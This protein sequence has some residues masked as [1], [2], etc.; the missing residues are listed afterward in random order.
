MHC[1]AWIP[2][3][4][5]A[6]LA[7]GCSREGAQGSQQ[8]PPPVVEFTHPVM[9]EV[10]DYEY[11]PGR[12]EAVNTVDVRA[13]VTGYLDRIDKAFKEGYEVAEKEP[14]CEIDSRLYNADLQK[15]QANLVQA[16]AHLK[17]LETEY[18]RARTLLAQR[19]TS[20]E[21]YDKAAG[22][23]DEAVAAVGVARAARDYSQLNVGFCTVNAPISGRV[24]RRMVD[25]GNLIKADDTIITTIVSLDPM[26]ASFDVDERTV[27]RIRRLIR[28]GKVKSARE[29]D[30]PVEMALADDL[31]G[32][33]SHQGTINFVDNRVDPGTGTLRVRARFEDPKH[34]LSPGLFVRL[35]VPIGQSHQAICVPERAVGT[36]QGEKF[37][38]ILNDQ[39]EAFYRRVVLG[40]QQEGGLIVVEPGKP[41]ETLTSLD[42]VVVTGLQR[43]HQST[44]VDPRPEG[45]LD[46][47]GS[48]TEGP[49]PVREPP[50]ATNRDSSATP[51]PPAP[52]DRQP[53][54]P[55]SREK[56]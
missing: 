34:T 47:E 15:A 40:P 27:L 53:Q 41:A 7:A 28:E 23:R 4:V 42:R 21:D 8:L 43:I 39:N 12:T 52:T 29:T 5:A 37:V 1:R 16:E 38:Y 35:R 44:K 20:R 13:R 11:F 33:F 14:L 25:P 56:R 54:R 49:G 46:Q 6:A 31:A 32:V 48:G 10:T 51:R 45:S 24:G 3:L 9:K 55:S 50:R 19:S 26:Y 22:D 17:R 2:V 30:V 36:D 18:T